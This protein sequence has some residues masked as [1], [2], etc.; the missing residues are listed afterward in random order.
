MRFLRTTALAGL[1]LGVAA[2]AFAQDEEEPDTIVV[3]G[4]RLQQ[5]NIFASSPVTTI[6]SEEFVARGTVDTIDLVNIL[7]SVTAGQTNEVSNGATGASTL[8]LRG[9]GATRTLVLVDGKRLPAG[10]ANGVASGGAF[11]SD[12]N[13]IPAPLIERVEVVTGGA[14]A[15]YGSDAIGGV[16]NFILRRDFEGLEVN[17][18]GGFNWDNNNNTFAQNVLEATSTDGVVPDGSVTDGR[19]I[20]ISGVFGA[21]TADGKGNVTGYVRYLDQREILQGTRDGGR[22]ALVPGGEL[23]AFCAGSNFGPFPTTLTGLPGLGTVSLDA[24]GNVPFDANGDVVDAATNAFNFNPLNFYQRPVSRFNAGFMARYEVNKHAEVYLDFGFTDNFTD[25][26]IAPTATFG[27]VQ[28]INCDNPFLSPDLFDLICGSQGLGVDDRASVNINRRNVE[29]GGRND[30]IELT[31]YRFVG[32]TRGE[33]APGIDYDVFAQFSATRQTDTSTNGWNVQRLLE[34]LDAVDDG[35]G[36]IVCRSGAAGCVP[37]NLFGTSPVDPAAL[38]Y[39][40]TPTLL[41]GRLQQTVLG[42]TMSFDGG[43]FGIKSPLASDGALGLVGAEWRR[44]Q[45]ENTAD[46]LTTTGAIAG[47]GGAEPP[48]DAETTVW[49]IFTEASV[50][51]IQDAPFIKSLG[52]SGAYRYSNYGATNL[53]NPA[54]VDQGEFETNAFSA[55][56][57]W[58][59]VEDIRLRAQFQRA[60]RAPN[61][62]N[63]FAGQRTQLFDDEDPCSGPDP[64]ARFNADE[65][66]NGRTFTEA[67]VLDRCVASGLDEALFGLVPADAGQLQE[68]SGGNPD[69]QEESSDTFTIGAVIQPRYVPGLTVSV[70]YFDIA[71]EDYI[72]SIPGAQTVTE[73]LFEGNDAFCDLFNRDQLGTIQVDGFISSE[74]RNIAEFQTRGVDFNVL[75]SFAASDF[76]LPDVGSFD[77]NLVST[78]T[79]TVEFTPGPGLGSFD[80]I[81]QFDD[82]CDGLIGNPSFSYRQNLSTTWRSNY[83]VDVRLLWRY[84]SAVDA[85]G[86]VPAGETTYE[87]QNYLDLFVNWNV[88]DDLSLYGGVNNLNNADAP[89]NIF[90]RGNGN[91]FPSVYEATG[92]FVFFGARVNL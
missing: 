30:R 8:N 15:V 36:N 85:V 66:A 34:S 28:D 29:G 91:T 77:L 44:D 27:T 20:D 80:C 16:A 46:F 51:L 2:P 33:V 70:D 71:I 69:L 63:L 3:T 38:D 4:S 42:G 14:S 31:N 90:N 7:P 48:V 59:P 5:A 64:V 81:E 82:A 10:R 19:V 56:L 87:A 6:G 88:R 12:I 11:A 1:A 58:A 22:C 79:D 74:I 32:G 41:T 86:L 21:N 61:I 68:F 54:P 23:G 26:Q 83:D 76:G 25:A 53:L 84:L 92:R 45:L 24:N 52:I 89:L 17:V 9:L 40:S 65:A 72:D 49:E 57:S 50:P 55:G 35:N 78:W 18:L 47:T 39:I 60:V 62:F 75:Y 13:I 43:R 73:C 37:L 67:E